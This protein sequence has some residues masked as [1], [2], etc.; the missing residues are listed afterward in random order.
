M[1]VCFTDNEDVN[2]Q[3]TADLIPITH[4]HLL[5]I[6]C[7]GTSIPFEVP[8]DDVLDPGSASRAVY[9]N[10]VNLYRPRTL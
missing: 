1:E 2:E 5:F 7:F 10:A 9:E 6:S 3:S 4:I 8:F